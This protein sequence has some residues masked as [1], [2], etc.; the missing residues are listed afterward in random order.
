[1][2]R[3]SSKWNTSVLQ[4]STSLSWRLREEKR[5]CA[6]IQPSPGAAMP[7]VHCHCLAW[8]SARR[9]EDLIVAGVEEPVVVTAGHCAHRQ[10][11]GR[12]R[13]PVHISER[14]GICPPAAQAASL[15]DEQCAVRP[16]SNGLRV[17]E[18]VG[19]TP[20][21]PPDQRGVPSSAKSFRQ[22]SNQS[23]TTT[24][25]AKYIASSTKPMPSPM[26]RP[27]LADE[28]AER[29]RATTAGG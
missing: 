3:P 19:S 1:M 23:S 2:N 26:R 16:D 17:L 6:N 13:K 5:F 22:G 25:P 28:S 24:P 10:V 12:N 29:S 9:V 4:M 8:V 20:A 14:V 27:K 11:A 21:R 7:D 15:K 18:L